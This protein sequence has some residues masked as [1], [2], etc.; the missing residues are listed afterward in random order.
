MDDQ[1]WCPASAAGH[2]G[3]AAVSAPVCAAADGV[4]VACSQADLGP[5]PKTRAPLDA[6]RRTL[7]PPLASSAT[8]EKTAA[9][10]V[11]SADAPPA[12]DP[13]T[14]IARGTRRS[15][16]QDSRPA[17]APTRKAPIETTKIHR[18]IS[19]C[20]F[21]GALSGLVTAAP[22]PGGTYLHMLGSQWSA[23][24]VTDRP[25]FSRWRAELRPRPVSRCSYASTPSELLV[26][27]DR[28]PYF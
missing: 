7:R 10:A 27:A 13:P 3:I 20:E 8:Q 21:T 12:A 28:S 16:S 5:R 2:A 24:V 6:S 22:R 19:M 26:R 1:F 17:A 14:S 18:A 23:R 25:A 4:T 9:T 11:A 15:S